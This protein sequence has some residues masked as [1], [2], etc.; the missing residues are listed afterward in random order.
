[1]KAA[2]VVIALIALIAVVTA[3]KATYI[4]YS[5]LV[6]EVNSKQSSWTAQLNTEI[7]DNDFT[8][9]KNLLGSLEAGVESP[10]P[11]KTSGWSVDVKDLPANFMPSDKWPQCRLSFET[12]HDQSACGSCWAVSS[13]AAA[14]E[15]YCIAQGNPTL[16]LS[17]RDILSCCSDCG[18]GCNGGWPSSAWSYITNHGIPTGSPDNSNTTLCQRYPFLSCMHHVDGTPQCSDYDFS[19]PKCAKSCDEESSW[20]VPLDKDRVRSK[21]SYSV[22]GESNLMKELYENGPITVSYTVYED[23]MAYKSGIYQHTT[24]R[25]LGGHAVT[26][27]G[28]GVDPNTNE[29]YWVIKNNWNSKWG[30]SGHFRIVRGTNNCGIEGSGNTG[31]F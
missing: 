26:L 21:K 22:S 7:L 13:G 15:R 14:S 1:M 11:A 19:T 9:I 6:N 28:W 17:T 29:K 8:T 3:D 23:F 24:G 16:F 12:V 18:M 25:S 31:L 4:R 20:P 10:L 30:E 27:E 2:L 5:E